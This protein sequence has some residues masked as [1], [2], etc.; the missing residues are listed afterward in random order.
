MKCTEEM[1]N[2]RKSS[3]LSLHTLHIPHGLKGEE[4]GLVDVT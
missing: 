1:I 4:T 3:P 2:A